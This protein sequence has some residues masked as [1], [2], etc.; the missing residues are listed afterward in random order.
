MA[1]KVQFGLKNCYYAKI[2][3]FGSPNTY[4]TP[5]AIPGAVNLNLAA[6]GET[7]KFYADD[8]VFFS[9]VTNTGFE[10]DLEMAKIPDQML[11]DIFGY[12][13]TTTSKC[14][15]DNANAEPAH[16][17]LL[18]E[19]NGDVQSERYVMY[20]C[21]ATRPAIGSSTTETSKSPVTQSI[22]ITAVPTSSGVSCRRTTVNTP[23]QTKN[24]WFTAV[25]T[26]TI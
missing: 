11:K 1:N 3:A 19:I 16:F 21:V 17:A 12:T 5:I 22:S 2:S 9:S 24:A 4:A 25:N 18:F 14:L 6:Q 26:A 13:E 23:A 7:N 8:T 20:D 15:D 10:G